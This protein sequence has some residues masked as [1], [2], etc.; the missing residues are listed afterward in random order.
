[1]RKN[2]AVKKEIQSTST[3]ISLQAEESQRLVELVRMVDSEPRRRSTFG[4]WLW[5]ATA[6][7]LPISIAAFYLFFY[8]S[9]QYAST[10]RYIVQSDNTQLDSANE[11]GMAGARASETSELYVTNFMLSDYLSSP[12]IVS[13]LQRTFDLRKMF[14]GDD[15]DAVARL[16]QDASRE[17][18]NRY[19]QGRVVTEFDITTGL[20]SVTVISFDPQEAASLANQMVLLSEE[21]VNRLGDRARQDAVRLAENAVRDTQTEM[22]EARQAVQDFREASLSVNP[23]SDAG[24]TDDLL[25][26]LNRQYVEVTTQLS[27]LRSQL[28]G[29]ARLITEL[30]RKARSLSE[31]ID[32][33]RFQ[34]ASGG[35]LGSV[36]REAYATQLRDYQNLQLDLDIATARYQSAV[37]AAD[38]AR[39]R[40]NRKHIYI[41]T[42]VYPDTPQTANG[43]NEARMI[44][45]VAAC[46][47][48]FWVTSSLLVATVRE[49]F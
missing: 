22:Q 13:E 46:A 27:V 2:S 16:P 35:A 26:T 8:A 48:A 21:L 33:A 3:N 38:A 7:L 23:A 18:L 29:E 14:S 4:A 11:S 12:Q 36:S 5:F 28:N 47:I 19:W 6:V 32:A 34:V 1:M 37:L 45:V 40:A 44:V 43:R 30:E 20:T 41:Q 49:N 17:A 10:F 15:I 25:A 9:P 42:Y 31:A 24:M 39:D